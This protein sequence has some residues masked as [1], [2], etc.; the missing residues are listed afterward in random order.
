LCADSALAQL[1]RGLALTLRKRLDEA[2][3][4]LE[5][6]TQIEPGLYE[7]WYYYGRVAMQLGQTERAIQ[8]MKQAATIRPTDYQS[9][10]LLPQLY[11]DLDDEASE[12]AWSREGLER[13]HR[14]LELH[15]D[16][17]RA[18]YLAAGAL[19]ALDQEAE[20]RTMMDR[21]VALGGEETGLFYNAACFYARL[22]EL[23]RAMDWLERSPVG[24][25]PGREWMENDADLA[26]LRGHPRFLAL[27]E[28]SGPTRSSTAGP[29]G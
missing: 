21:A 15:P 6:A 14:H 18:M 16:D 25:L 12:A 10:M 11:R 13:A 4:H 3:V 2:A 29:A 24:R 7:A 23:D 1:A 20:A 22:G 19:L 8:L 17:Y 26:G 9:A 27:L 28:E 5:R